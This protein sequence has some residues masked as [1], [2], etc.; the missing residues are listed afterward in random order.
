MPRASTKASELTSKVMRAKDAWE[1]AKLR[2]EQAKTEYEYAEKRLVLAR[3]EL[4]LERHRVEPGD[5][6]HEVTAGFGYPEEVLDALCSVE[7]VGESIGQASR[8][9]LLQLRKA[10]V[11]RLVAYMR[12]RGFQ[13]ATDVPARELHGALVKQPWAKKDRKTD[14]WEYVAE[15]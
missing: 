6:H 2:F 1:D 4:G 12:E 14:K 10:T 7:L 3:R 9:A 5:W 8:S 13:F 11:A 15:G